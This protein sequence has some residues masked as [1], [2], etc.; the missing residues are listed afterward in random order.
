MDARETTKNVTVKDKVYQLHKM[1]ARSACWLYTFIGSRIKDG[2][3]VMMALGSCTRQEYDTIVD[4]ALKHVY[5]LDPDTSKG[6]TFLDPVVSPTGG[7]I[8]DLQF[9]A[10]LMLHLVSDSCLFNLKPF[11]VVVGSKLAQDT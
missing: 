6:S 10:E 8:G 7:L 11:L 3:P 5:H 2:Q 4:L 1:D 9:D